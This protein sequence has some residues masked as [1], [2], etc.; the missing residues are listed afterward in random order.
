MS[1]QET[2][3]NKLLCPKCGSRQTGQVKGE[4]P[5]EWYCLGHAG[6]FYDTSRVIRERRRIPRDHVKV[7]QGKADHKRGQ[8]HL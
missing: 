1:E 7:G 6:T 4:D 5:E 2:G 3:M 8:R